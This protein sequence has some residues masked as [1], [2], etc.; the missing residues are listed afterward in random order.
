[1]TFKS[2]KF[3]TIPIKTFLVAIL[4]AHTYSI[5]AQSICDGA[6]TYDQ[7]IALFE[8]NYSVT[9]IIDR[10]KQD[11]IKFLL[12][13]NQQE[14]IIKKY[15][16]NQG[17]IKIIN[18][19]FCE[20]QGE[21]NLVFEGSNTIGSILAPRLILGYLNN[22][23]AYAKKIISTCDGIR[24]RISSIIG[25]ENIIFDIISTGSEDGWQALSNGKADIAMSSEQWI[26]Q[27]PTRVLEVT[28]ARDRVAVIV[29]PLNPLSEIPNDR[30]GAVFGGTI[31]DWND[32]GVHLG[33][34][35][36]TAINVYSRR[37]GSG[38]LAEFEQ[39]AHLKV[40]ISIATIVDTHLQL[41][42][43]VAADIKGIGFVALPYAK[44]TKELSVIDS[45]RQSIGFN[46]ELYLY[47]YPRS[48]D[49]DNFIEFVKDS[50]GQQTIGDVGFLPVRSTPPPGSSGPLGYDCERSILPGAT[51]V[52]AKI[53]FDFGSYSII[54]RINLTNVIKH[55]P[56]EA[57]EIWIIGFTD[58]LGSREL[59]QKLSEKRAET[60]AG[61]LSAQGISNVKKYSCGERLYGNDTEAGR[62]LNR[63]VEIW[64]RQQVP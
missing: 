41:A 28:I 52:E 45:A 50:K 6:L 55:I 38:T 56:R 63:T 20:I 15:G 30:L 48:G 19:N 17:L 25:R 4:L 5:W 47:Y 21:P 31:R 1:M 59:N 14:E 54:D 13:P 40:N 9:K 61:Y 39:L 34:G 23:N 10:V 29:N 24:T 11:K 36:D 57:R 7:L 37:K 3:F 35:K 46:R 26:N 33:D 42:H 62:R 44:L 2:A 18:E 22:A 64:Y 12:C 43:R 58:S 8:T 51:K 27:K 16:G 60:V 53:Y 49:V 32:L